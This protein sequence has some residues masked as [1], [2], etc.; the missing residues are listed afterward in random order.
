MKLEA[1]RLTFAPCLPEDWKTY[2][3]HYRYRETV[4][5][6]AILQMHAANDGITV[7]VDGVEQD[8]DFI[9]LVD[10]LKEHRVEVRISAAQS[11]SN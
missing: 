10:D 4:Y 7:T 9:H 2:K 1:D 5:H 3:A 6:I 8:D 11:S